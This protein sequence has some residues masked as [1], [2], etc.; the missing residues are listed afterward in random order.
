MAQEMGS[1]ALA[2]KAFYVTLT[3]CVA[4]AATVFVFIL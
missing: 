4:F 2:R 3:F 1:E